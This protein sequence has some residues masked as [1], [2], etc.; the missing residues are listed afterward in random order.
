VL[1]ATGACF[2]WG[3]FRR[4][5]MF[6][7]ATIGLTSALAFAITTAGPP[8]NYVVGPGQG[9]DGVV[10]I[11]GSAKVWGTGTLLP[12]RRHVLTS[13][14]VAGNGSAT[15]T[16][17]LPTGAETLTSTATIFHSTGFDMVL[18]RLPKSMPISV[19]AYE[20]YRGSDEMGK[21]GQLI[22]YGLG[23]DGTK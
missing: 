4:V 13:N 12:S 23:G 21:V 2:L 19:D 16:F 5:L 7:F 1:F 6:C 20:I 14:Q 17:E 9:R 3:R 18:L 10:L 22:G 8:E 11:Q 15:V